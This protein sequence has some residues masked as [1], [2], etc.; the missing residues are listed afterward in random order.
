MSDWRS[1]RRGMLSVYLQR[2]IYTN[3]FFEC[4]YFLSGQKRISIEDL[5]VNTGA[6]YFICGP[7]SLKESVFDNL[8]LAGIN[9][10]NIHTEHFVDGYVPWFG[11]I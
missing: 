2:K 8:H 4:Q 1:R 3:S 9:K 7:D 11:L 10:N 5:E 6:N